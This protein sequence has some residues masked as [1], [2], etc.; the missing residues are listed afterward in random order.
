MLY[1][2]SRSS[3]RYLRIRT[4]WHNTKPELSGWLTIGQQGGYSVV[5]SWTLQYTPGK[6]KVD[7]WYLT[8]VRTTQP[9]LVHP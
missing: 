7:G 3:S 5:T 9:K 1:G 6:Q 2:P 4:L 8:L